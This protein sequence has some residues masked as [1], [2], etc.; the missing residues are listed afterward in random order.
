MLVKSLRLIN[1][2]KLKD[3][4]FEFN[5]DM[6]I[7]VGDNNAGKSTILEALEIVLNFQ[8]RRRP[9]GNEL[10]S[11]VGCAAVCRPCDNPSCG[12]TGCTL[13]ILGFARQLRFQGNVWRAWV[14]TFDVPR[15]ALRSGRREPR[16]ST[17]ALPLPGLGTVP[18]ALL[19]TPRP[20]HKATTRV[21][22]RL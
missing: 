21:G 16:R 9:F 5:D 19:R 17:G 13:G 12:R 4:I 2:K 3:Q 7:F 6:N 11:Q 8:H 22:Q 1:F 18:V 15:F 10:E 20:V 14:T